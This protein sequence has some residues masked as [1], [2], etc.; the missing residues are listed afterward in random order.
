MKDAGVWVDTVT[1]ILYLDTV[2]QILLLGYRYFT[3]MCDEGCR[4]VGG[5][6]SLVTGYFTTRADDLV[7][8]AHTGDVG[9]RGVSC[10]AVVLRLDNSSLIVG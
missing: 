6:W 7:W 3:Y 8:I 9:F 2:T 10:G 5:Y 4:R 1:R